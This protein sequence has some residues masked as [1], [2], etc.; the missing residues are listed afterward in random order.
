MPKK[1]SEFD[2]LRVRHAVHS[3]ILTDF[4]PLS[5]TVLSV[6]GTNQYNFQTDHDLKDF[7]KAGDEV[8]VKDTHLLVQTIGTFGTSKTQAITFRNITRTKDDAAFS[9]N[10]YVPAVGEVLH[11]RAFKPTATQNGA[12]NT[13]LTDFVMMEN[14]FTNLF[15]E[16]IV[17]GF[18]KLVATATATDPD[19]K[20]ITLRQEINREKVRILQLFAKGAPMDSTQASVLNQKLFEINRLNSMLGPIDTIYES[21]ITDDAIKEAENIMKK[22]V[23]KKETN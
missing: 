11:R 15:V 10:T 23:N 16:F 2:S 14:R 6:L 4:F 12:S 13:L 9:A 17:G 19:K 5:A 22:S 21:E 18:A 1:V 8:K 3:A 20:L 7:L